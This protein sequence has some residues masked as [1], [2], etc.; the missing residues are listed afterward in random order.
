MGQ[1]FVGPKVFSGGRGAVLE[2]CI[3]SRVLLGVTRWDNLLISQLRTP[4]PNIQG[5]TEGRAWVRQ[6][7][8]ENEARIMEKP[9]E[10]HLKSNEQENSIS[11]ISKDEI[12][13]KEEPEM[14][15][16]EVF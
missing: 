16:N 15:E 5:L 9:N 8:D 6:K 10:N 13:L 14:V 2:I 4:N 12:K 11:E 3:A 1:F 7:I